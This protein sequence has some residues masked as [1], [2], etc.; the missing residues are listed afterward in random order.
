MIELFLY[1]FAGTIVGICVSFVPGLFY[2]EISL[3]LF[4]L[5]SGIESAVFI[6]SSA[7][8]FS[9]FEF[10]STNIFEIGDDITSFSIGVKFES[11]NLKRIAK[12][13]SLGTL[14]GFFLS[15]PLLFVF[16]PLYS[17]LNPMIKPA[18]LVILIIVI[19]YTIVIEK[20]FARKIF[21]AFIF[22]GTGIFGALVSN[23]GFL[24]SD[25][26]LMPV[27]IGLFGF[28]SI[29]ARKHFE[30]QIVF[31]L[32]TVEKIKVSAISFFATLVGIFIPSMKRSQISAIVF[33]AGKFDQSE[34]VLLALS[35][36]S[37]SFL[38]L[39]IIALSVNSIRSTLSYSI[40]NTVEEINYNQVLIVLGSLVLAAAFSIIFLL[41]IIN[42]LE[43]IVGRISKKYLKFFG[44]GCGIALITY[45]TFW[46]GLLLAAIATT[47]GILAIKLK[48]R[49]AHLMG[50]LLV[51][52][53]LRLA[54][55]PI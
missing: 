23:S 3:L 42:H 24:P 51:P 22:V 54:G 18:L 9:I 6:A 15:L 41:G 17:V 21:A 45:F 55:F 52:T 43:K 28:S 5:L 1:I 16:Q 37:T 35:I 49:S 12:T 33:D 25:L 31:Q 26:L 8:A 32:S 19:F 50:V 47:I 53:L 34:T 7:I 38:I 11:E 14:I 10:V 30:Q 4:G 40:M 36:I 44:I 29:I 39:S 20:G 46:K 27:F 48:V 13:V 2:S